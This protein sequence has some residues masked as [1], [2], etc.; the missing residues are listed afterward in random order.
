MQQIQCSF[1]K[2]QLL[3]QSLVTHDAKSGHAPFVG[4]LIF[5]NH[6][7]SLSESGCVPTKQRDPTDEHSCEICLRKFV[8]TTTPQIRE[9]PEFFLLNKR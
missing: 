6:F 5:V 9:S 7:F 2:N 4:L 1:K 8:V 3:S